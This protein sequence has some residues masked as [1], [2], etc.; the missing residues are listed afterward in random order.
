MATTP[1]LIFKSMTEPFPVWEE[2]PINDDSLEYVQMGEWLKYLPVA[3]PRLN[4][5]DPFVTAVQEAYR[6][7]EPGGIFKLEVP[8]CMHSAGVGHPLQ[9][10]IFNTFTFAAFGR[11]DPDTL[12]RASVVPK[13]WR[14][15]SCG[16]DFGTRFEILHIARGDDVAPSQFISVSYLKPEEEEGEPDAAE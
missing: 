2:W 8:N 16:M 5:P 13:E 10:R 15:D 14:W 7:L 4:E 1:R 9:H 6:C 3:D 11:P 12:K